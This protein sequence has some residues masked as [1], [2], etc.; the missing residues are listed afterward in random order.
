MLLPSGSGSEARCRSKIPGR[1]THRTWGFL[2]AVSLEFYFRIRF[3]QRCFVIWGFLY[4]PELFTAA[5]SSVIFKPV[6]PTSCHLVQ[7]LSEAQVCWQWG[8][9]AEWWPS[10]LW[11]IAKGKVFQTDAEEQISKTLGNFTLCF[12]ALHVA[13]ILGSC[14]TSPVKALCPRSLLFGACVMRV[15]M[16]GR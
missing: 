10:V 1:G 5:V 7:L 3:K 12:R 13:P 14:A 8:M 15:G 2:R 6:C 16:M 4:S 9:P 11:Q